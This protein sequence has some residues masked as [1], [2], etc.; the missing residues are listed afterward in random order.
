MPLG[1]LV[2]IFSFLKEL[3][4]GKTTKNQKVI[5]SSKIRKWIVL[6]ILI[7]SLFLN[8]QS[9]TKLFTVTQK[10]IVVQKENKHYREQLEKAQQC[11]KSLEIVR[12]W[13]TRCIEPTNKLQ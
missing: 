2:S 8:Y 12:S 3:V 1:T 11:E 7:V 10:Y 13:L 5:L 6:I 9:I 4:F